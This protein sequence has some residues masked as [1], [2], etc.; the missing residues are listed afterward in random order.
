LKLVGNT[1]EKPKEDRRPGGPLD[2]LVSISGRSTKVYVPWNQV[3]SILQTSVPLR[4]LAVLREVV[5]VP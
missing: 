5:F 3:R 4:S 2:F 1:A